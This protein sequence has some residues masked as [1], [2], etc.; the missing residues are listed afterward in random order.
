MGK[1]FEYYEC[2]LPGEEW[3][4]V[5]GYKDVYKI[6][7]LGRVMSLPKQAGRQYRH[8]KQILSPKITQY[9]YRAV[10]LSVNSKVKHIHVHRL[11][12]QAFI[13]NPE[14]KPFVNHIDGNKLNNSINNLE[15]CTND[16]N[17]KHAVDTG[18]ISFKGE[19]NPSNKLSKEQALDIFTSD[20]PY[21][22]LVEKY[23][24]SLPLI[25]KIRSG[26]VW[27]SVTGLPNK[28]KR[29]AKSK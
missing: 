2:D 17:M 18:L 3:R 23:N 8:R 27:S 15:W 9:G 1:K 29:Y 16:E 19:L 14:N 6:S 21:K 4:N 24:I 26:H 25:T 22:D 5:V 28:R 12:A 10:S 13:P 11:I 20:R 7:S